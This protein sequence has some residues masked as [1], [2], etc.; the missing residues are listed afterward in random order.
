MSP[1]IEL[2]HDLAEAICE[3]ENICITEGQTGSESV[4]LMLWIGRTYPDLK[5]KYSF[6]PWR[7]Y[8][9]IEKE[10][11]RLKAGRKYD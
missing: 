3:M 5:E 1:K 11:A 7:K 8:A 2:P 10:L 6:F 4:P 9:L